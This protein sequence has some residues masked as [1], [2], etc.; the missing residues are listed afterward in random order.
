MLRLRLF[1]CDVWIAAYAQALRDIGLAQGEVR[2]LTLL[3]R[4]VLE[5]KRLE[6][7]ARL[8]E[9]KR[10]R[11]LVVVATHVRRASRRF[12]REIAEA[13]RRTA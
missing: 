3:E 5:E 10:R 13:A 2:G 7:G 11:D 4:N 8:D 12:K 1:W 6:A 9:W